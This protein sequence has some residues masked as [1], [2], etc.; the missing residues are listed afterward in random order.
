MSSVEIE[1]WP[2]PIPDQMHGARLPESGPRHHT[3]G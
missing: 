1:L 3:P 2:W